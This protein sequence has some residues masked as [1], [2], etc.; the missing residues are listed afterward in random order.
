M[1]SEIS[2]EDRLFELKFTSKQLERQ[3]KKMEK[4]EKEEKK[5]VK[6]AIE[7][8]NMDGA[9][10]YAENSIR[11]KTQSLNYIRLAGRVDAVAARVETAVRMQQ[12]T[13][14][15]AG[16][17]QGMD[18]A[19]KSMDLQQISMLMDRYKE[20]HRFFQKT[21]KIFAFL[22]IGLTRHLRTSMYSP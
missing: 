7:K 8:G 21:L 14:S 19:L 17:V 2:V 9:R 22:G 11:C 12:I 18:A 16:V 20:R 4:Q 13:K 3:S 6:A 15:M 1:G 10:I 5:K